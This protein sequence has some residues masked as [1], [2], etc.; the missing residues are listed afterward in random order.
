M[1]EE[2]DDYGYYID[3]EIDL[4]TTE[5]NDKY[6]YN[7]HYSSNDESIDYIINKTKSDNEIYYKKTP[8]ALITPV[9]IICIFFSCYLFIRIWICQP[10]PR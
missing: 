5:N 7:L 2:T 10:L 6:I 3:I 1:L 4:N 9:N 8:F